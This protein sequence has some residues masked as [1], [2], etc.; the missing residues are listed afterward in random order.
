MVI[1][2]YVDYCM[3]RKR[4][5]ILIFCSF[6]W[7]T[8]YNSHNCPANC[9]FFSNIFH[10]KSKCCPLQATSKTDATLLNELRFYLLKSDRNSITCTK[11]G[12][13][14]DLHEVSYFVSC[15]TSENPHDR[16]EIEFSGMQHQ[17]N[18]SASAALGWTTSCGSAAQRSDGG[19]RDL[20]PHQVRK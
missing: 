8:N 16:L 10:N 18:V 15:V 2:L 9:I 7:A 1:D 20:N 13:K 5:K 6:V 19:S 4:N 12:T 17:P 14:A 11:C 3:V